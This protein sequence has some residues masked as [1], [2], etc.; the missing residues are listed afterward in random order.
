M[1]DIAEKLIPQEKKIE[2][3]LCGNGEIKRVKMILEKKGIKQYFNI[4]GCITDKEKYFK[5]ANIFVLPSY[6]EGVPISILEA[7]SYSLPIIATSV[8]GIP[9]VIEDGVNGFLVNPGDIEAFKNKILKLIRSVSLRNKMGKN[10]Y[11]SVKDKFDV[12][13]I[14]RQLNAIYQELSD[15]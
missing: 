15:R 3:I 5:D 11:Y 1:I 7:A 2:F 4:P 13:I 8:G 9:E 14:T 6:Y 12:N 10:A